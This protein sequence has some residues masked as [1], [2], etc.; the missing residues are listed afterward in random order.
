V[1]DSSHNAT[2]VFAAGFLLSTLGYRS[3]AAWEERLEPLGLN[4]R[5]AATLIHVARAHGQPQLRLAQTLRIAPSRV[6][7]LVDELERRGLLR[8][9]TDRA[10]RR[11]RTLRLTAQGRAMV[12]TL[13]KITDAH[14]AWLLTGLNDAERELLL[15]LLKRVAAGLDVSETA[16]A[17]LGGPEWGHP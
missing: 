15:T 1:A 11:V 7:T 9:R 3:H 14:E 4:S 2:P 13:A 6:V 12:R 17:G 10:D 16:H 5:Q 8:R